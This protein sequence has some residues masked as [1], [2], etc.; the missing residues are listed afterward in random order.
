MDG[1][2]MVS[3]GNGRCLG[4]KD[5]RPEPRKRIEAGNTVAELAFAGNC[6][7]SLY[8]L[9]EEPDVLLTGLIRGFFF[10]KA[11]LIHLHLSPKNPQYVPTIPFGFKDGRFDVM[12]LPIEKGTRY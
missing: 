8:L 2:R 10:C 6:F 11:L 9:F 3:A 1:E 4:F 12:Y 7:A 5:F